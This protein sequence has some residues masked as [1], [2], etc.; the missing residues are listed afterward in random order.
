MSSSVPWCG[1][2]ASLPHACW[3]PYAAAGLRLFVG[4]ACRRAR[5]RPIVPADPESLAGGILRIASRHSDATPFAGSASC[6]LVALAIVSLPVRRCH[7]SHRIQTSWKATLAHRRSLLGRHSTPSRCGC[8]LRR[9]FMVPPMEQGRAGFLPNPSRA[10]DVVRRGLRA[11]HM[12]VDPGCSDPDPERSRPECASPG[13]QNT[14]SKP[15]I[16]RRHG[17]RIPRRRL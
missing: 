14:R 5:K 17:R 16:V 4:R 2:S 6:E 3:D 7:S 1:R 10:L 12:V 8:N 13:N 9:H 11:A 15:A